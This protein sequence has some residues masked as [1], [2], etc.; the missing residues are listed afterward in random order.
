MSPTPDTIYADVSEWQVPVNDRYPHRVL[1][2]RSNDGD[3]RDRNWSTNYSWCQSRC[4]D[5]ELDFFI[6]YFVWRRNWRQ[7]VDTLKA[8]VG[9]PHPRMAVMIDVEGW[10]GQITGD[11]SDG[12]NRAYWA[13]ADWVGEPRRVIGYGNVGDLNRL[14]PV[15]PE[16]IR[17]VVAAYGTN[18]DYPGKVAHQY[19]DDHRYG[20]ATTLPNG[21]PPFGNCDMNSADGLTPAQFAAACGLPSVIGFAQR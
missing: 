18:P 12:I 1:C 20:N 13:V 3:H 10:G 15:K 8:M 6:V 5:G 16:G 17:L 11:Q 14:W 9:E 19:T 2:I 7:T 4:D 21:A